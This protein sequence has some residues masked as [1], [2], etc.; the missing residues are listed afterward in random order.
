MPREFL[1][2][3]TTAVHKPLE[4]GIKVRILVRQQILSNCPISQAVR[5]RSAK[6]LRI[7]SN[8][9]L[10]SHTSKGISHGFKNRLYHVF[11][12]PDES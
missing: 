6:P 12:I 10:D 7:G 9:I 5:R 8:P 11:R 4:L 2:Y 3:R 1:P